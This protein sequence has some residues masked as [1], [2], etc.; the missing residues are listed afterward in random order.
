[1]VGKYYFN[2]LIFT[3]LSQLRDDI[4]LKNDHYAFK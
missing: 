1:M 3:K 2:K 4:L